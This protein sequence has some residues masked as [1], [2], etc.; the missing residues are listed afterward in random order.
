MAKK[1]RKNR[2]I[3]LEIY[4][5]QKDDATNRFKKAQNRELNAGPLRQDRWVAM[6][7]VSPG[8]PYR[9]RC[10]WSC[11]PRSSTSGKSFI[12]PSNIA[13]AEDSMC[14]PWISRAKSGTSQAGA[15]HL[16]FHLETHPGRVWAGFLLSSHQVRRDLRVVSLFEWIDTK[17]ASTDE[18][19]RIFAKPL[20]DG[21]IPCATR[22]T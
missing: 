8:N 3:F 16:G 12:P 4:W 1:F 15:G 19:H 21:V 14:P 13:V 17:N 2:K 9:R 22:G 20:P 7:S 5:S 6:V 11:S 10:T 18:E